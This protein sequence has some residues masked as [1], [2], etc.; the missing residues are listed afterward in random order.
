MKQIKTAAIFFTCICLVIYLSFLFILPHFLNS[1]KVS[2]IVEDAL[3][4]QTGYNFRLD[5]PAISTS[6]DLHLIT[7]VEKAD[8]FFEHKKFAQVNN[9]KINISLVPLIL[10]KI[11]ITNINASK[12]IVEIPQ[13]L[14]IPE[15]KKSKFTL[16]EKYPDVNIG[17]F[18]L[19]LKDENNTYSLKGN[20]LAFSDNFVL[21]K[22]K[23]STNGVFLVNKTENVKYNINLI[24]QPLN[25]ENKNIN[26]I[27]ILQNIKSYNIKS[28]IDI[29]A[30]ISDLKNIKGLINVSDFSFVCE[31]KKYPPS[32]GVFNIDKN[33]IK[34]SSEI[35]TS[36]KN[37]IILNGNF[38]YGNNKNIDLNVKSDE[39]NISDILIIA[40]AVTKSLGINYF[41]KISASGVLKANFNIKSNFK[42]LLSDGNLYINNAKIRYDNYLLKDIFS[43]V[44]FSGN[45]IKL[46]NTKANIFNY[47]IHIKGI[48]DTK[49]DISVIADN[50]KIKD[51]VPKNIL[52][53]NDVEGIASFK[54]YIKGEL[55]N[56]IPQANLTISKL[57]VKN[58]ITGVNI[59]NAETKIFVI[60]KNANI[61]LFNT[62]LNMPDG[63]NS[64]LLP[65]ITA[66]LNGDVLLIEKTNFYIDNVKA[67][68]FGSISDI[69]KTPTFNGIK[70]SIPN[71]TNLS[72]PMNSKISVNGEMMLNGNVNNP[73]LK[74][75]VN[76]PKI[77]VP[78]DSLT[79]QN[80]LISADNVIKINCPYISL[81]SSV[82]RLNA[83]INN[84]LKP[85]ISI[86]NVYS[87]YLD[88]N[89][90]NAFTRKQKFSP[91]INNGTFK[92]NK[93][94]VNGIVAEKVVSKLSQKNNIMYLK[95]LTADA[96]YGKIAS[97]ITYDIKKNKTSLKL[98]G[99]GLD[100]H[101]ALNA[102]SGKEQDIQGKCDFDSEIS[103]VGNSQEEVQKSIKGNIKFVINN[104]V[105]NNLGKL[106]YLIQAQNILN[107][108]FKSSSINVMKNAL[109]LKDLG[110]YQSAKGD[111]HLDK[112]YAYIK[113]IKLAGPS[114]SLYMKGR[115]YIPD[116]TAF[117]LITGR[118]SDD[119]VT[120]L[121]PLGNT[122]SNPKYIPKIGSIASAF[123]DDITTTADLED[124]S[125]VPDLTVKTNFKTQ[126]FKVL[127]NGRVDKQTSVQSF[128]WIKQDKTTP[129]TP[130]FIHSKEQ[131]KKEPLPE[132]INKL[133]EYK[134]K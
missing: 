100:S 1:N 41:D 30:D 114:M 84:I 109:K 9:L 128:K 75:S 91:D 78:S 47:P 116:N 72:G 26:F 99:R 28:N 7:G 17:Y 11:K 68:I 55:N 119:V 64:V 63:I 35:F 81:N 129:T 131:P 43:K 21:K 46:E 125:Q 12:L 49:A 126:E 70:I 71:Q 37:K 115:Y 22:M 54:A 86:V 122:S 76:I 106:D 73:K 97:D 101:N 56:L 117:I 121:G 36:P 108:R 96:Y 15:Y 92:A 113:G 110:V 85:E 51:F 45:K 87:D 14:K 65:K 133:P 38:D 48:I 83:Q 89:K 134:N 112:G 33:K 5:N 127:I 123:L 23:L 107:N 95:G 93:I 77:T 60:G 20:N 6:W 118:V 50:I 102:V 29:K 10:K 24:F 120:A 69:F 67:E 105:S 44:D 40:K 16:F 2:K 61:N 3:Y 13:N 59:K 53:E 79:L 42:K 66:K 19:S 52:K 94:Y 31:G 104:F 18:R 82:I 90:L 32:F 39:I 8:V 74:G 58:K 132:F 98:Q 80:V 62:M 103:F 88:V 130:T 4:K 124:I 27:E 111:V 57:A 25:I 34:I